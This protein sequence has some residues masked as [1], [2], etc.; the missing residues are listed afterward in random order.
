MKARRSARLSKPLTLRDGRT[1]RTLRD[2]RDFVLRLPERDLE[3][4]AWQSAAGLLIAAANGGN[5]E[6]ATKQ[7]AAVLFLKAMV[8]LG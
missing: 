3:R 8:R 7:V 1:L 2:A 5:I 6:A 4:N